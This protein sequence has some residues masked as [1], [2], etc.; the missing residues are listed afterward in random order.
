MTEQ[1]TAQEARTM[2]AWERPAIL[3]M[4]AADAEAKPGA[5]AEGVS[6]MGRRS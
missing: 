2:A 5:I 1:T 4:A 3:R 6:G